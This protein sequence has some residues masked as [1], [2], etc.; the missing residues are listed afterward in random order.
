MMSF[1]F[2]IGLVS[3]AVMALAAQ[4]ALADL[5]PFD[6]KTDADGSMT[7]TMGKQI[8]VWC[9]VEH[10]QLVLEF[11]AEEAVPITSDEPLGFV[12]DPF[13]TPDVNAE[14]VEMKVAFEGPAHL[15]GRAPLDDKLMRVLEAEHMAVIAP[16]E[17]GEPWYTGRSDALL[18][19]ARSCHR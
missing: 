15:T 7:A 13:A 18:R 14:V 8:K 19:V 4:P 5:P 3:L 10:R 1:R 9:D 17:M 6:L 16:N 11:F 2:R 12:D